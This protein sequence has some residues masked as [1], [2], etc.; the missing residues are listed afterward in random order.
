MSLL[1]RFE[2][3]YFVMKTSCQFWIYGR[4]SGT[5]SKAITIAVIDNYHTNFA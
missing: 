1:K 5:T 4:Y 3:R 2:G